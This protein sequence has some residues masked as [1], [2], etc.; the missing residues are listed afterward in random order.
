MRPK[1]T[2]KTHE[3]HTEKLNGC[4][5]RSRLLS[6]LLNEI[7][8]KVEN[9][10]S[11][12]CCLIGTLEYTSLAS[13]FIRASMGGISVDGSSDIYRQLMPTVVDQIAEA[14]PEAV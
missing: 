12:R 10:S 8:Q 6:V 4:N 3:L 9:G 2:L 14:E 13:N 5:S 7:N 1:A 11:K